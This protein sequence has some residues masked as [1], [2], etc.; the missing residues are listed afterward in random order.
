MYDNKK[1]QSDPTIIQS[2]DDFVKELKYVFLN[3]R[4]ASCLNPYFGFSNLR[5]K[6]KLLPRNWLE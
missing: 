5:K 3:A 1:R 6:M 4:C 2:D